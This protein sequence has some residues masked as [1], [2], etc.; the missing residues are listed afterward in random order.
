M[1]I[2]LSTMMFL[3][4][5]TLSNYFFVLF[6]FLTT[7]F[8]QYYKHKIRSNGGFYVCNKGISFSI[9]FNFINFYII[10][11]FII[12][13]ALIAYLFLRKNL[14]DKPLLLLGLS[15]VASGTLSNILDRLLFGC[16]IDNL[17]FSGIN[18][19]FN[20]SD[21]FI[22]IGASLIFSYLISNT[23]DN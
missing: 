11:G 6:F 5:L 9:F 7:G 10:A 4:K 23:V 12:L 16:V 1:P 2:L 15:L 8:D 14:L 19:V 3:K 20:F 13:I 21:V 22:F 17:K 18:L